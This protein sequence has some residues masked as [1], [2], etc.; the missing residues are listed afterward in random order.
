MRG[1]RECNGVTQNTVYVYTYENIIVCLL[2]HIMNIMPII[3]TTKEM[4]M[5][6]GHPGRIPFLWSVWDSV[7]TARL[8]QQFFRN[9]KCPNS[10]PYCP[11]L[12]FKIPSGRR[13]RSR[14]RS[15]R[16]REKVFLNPLK[17]TSSWGSVASSLLMHLFLE[18]VSGNTE[19]LILLTLPPECRGYWQV[20]PFLVNCGAVD[21]TQGFVH[22]KY[23]LYRLSSIELYP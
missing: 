1:T 2:L 20:L 3:V 17:T 16:R 11:S 14:W 10:S 23:V 5:L 18:R 21:W 4:S 15:G 12:I 19:L 7:T 8:T 6:Q 13:T 9:G 22:G